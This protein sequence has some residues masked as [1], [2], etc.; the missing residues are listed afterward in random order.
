MARQETIL[1]VFV[2][3][4]SDVDE[5]RNC[6]EKVIRDLN[7]AWARELGIRLDLVRWETHAYPSFGEDP[8]AVI[9]A[10]I[11]NDFDLFIGLMWYR[12]GT[13]TGRTGSGTLEEFQR[14][15]ERFDRAPSALQL[16]IYFKDAPAPLPPSELDPEQLTKVG[17]FRSSLGK[18]GG[19]YWSFSTVD[20]FEKLVHLHLTRQVQAWQSK[21]LT[22]QP[23]KNESIILA[24]EVN[25][26]ALDVQGDELG[27]LDLMEQFEDEF[28][29]LQEITERIA[30]A[31]VDIGEKMQERTA[32]TEQFMAGPD[33]ANR[34]AVQRLL[35]KVAADM[36]QYVYRMDAELP[37][38]NHHLYAGMNALI[39]AS[40][41]TLEFAIE[42]EDFKQVKDN[43]E[44]VREFHETLATV[45]GQI[46]CF[47]EAV[48]NLPKMT[49]TLNRAKR[50]VVNALQRLIKEFQ[51]GQSMARE[52]EASFASLIE[53]KR[54][55]DTILDS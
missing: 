39:Q 12:F 48:E 53:Q 10:Q 5:E 18:E 36:D 4:P 15:K 13:P 30:S 54:G 33:A 17:E 47:Q 21:E 43:I 41:M 1:T 2:A 46:K 25:G 22:R 42:D 14:A 26:L 37:M 38:F 3:S 35:A 11:P 51:R 52:A 20:E 45:E 40:Q 6:L 23:G 9:N 19:L 24:K 32:E 29:A 8:Q 28:A 7:T 50:A 27:L 16:M 49:I 34:K 55:A 44:N 31:T